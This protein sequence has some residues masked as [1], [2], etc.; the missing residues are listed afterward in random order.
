MSGL[1]KKALGARIFLNN[2]LDVFYK[3]RG[4]QNKEQL[5]PRESE[6]TVGLN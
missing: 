3:N 4:K 5:F 2:N 1:Q 6:R